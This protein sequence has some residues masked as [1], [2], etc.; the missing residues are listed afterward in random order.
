MFTHMRRAAAKHNITATASDHGDRQGSRNLRFN[1]KTFNSAALRFG[2]HLENIC[3]KLRVHDRTE[4]VVKY[5]F[6]AESEK[7]IGGVGA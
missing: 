7:A 4:F 2:A 5:F 6:A 1:S 3:A